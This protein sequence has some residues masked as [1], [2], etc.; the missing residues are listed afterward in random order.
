M[1]R[2]AINS[3]DENNDSKPKDNTPSAILLEERQKNSM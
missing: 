3:E 2:I 1:I